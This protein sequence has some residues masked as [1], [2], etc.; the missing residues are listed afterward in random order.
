MVDSHCH[1]DFT[2]FDTDRDSLW[3]QCQ[4][5]GIGGLIVPGVSPDQWS[6]AQQL[7]ENLKGIYFAVGLH[8]WWL[9]KTNI[10]KIFFE[11]LSTYLDD[12]RCVALGECGLDSVIDTSMPQQLEVFEQQIA[13]ACDVRKPLIIHARKTHSETLSLLKRYL[14][15]QG[16]VIHGFSGSLEI[17]QAYWNLGFYLG[18]GGTIS[19]ERANKTREAIKQ[20][21]LESLLLETDAPDMPLQGRQGERNSPAYLQDIA[22]TL[23]DL[24]KLPVADIVRQTTDNTCCLFSIEV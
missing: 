23:A 20:M 1:F 22:Q 7:S 11:R 14:P 9:E 15:Q 8:P 4:Q 2:E 10:D 13:L 19:Y 16:G 12:P 21:P 24:K 17:A 3:Q 18:V 5:S 6:K